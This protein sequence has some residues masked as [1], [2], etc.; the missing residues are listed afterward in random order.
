MQRPVKKSQGLLRSLPKL[1]FVC[2]RF[3]AV[4]WLSIATVACNNTNLVNPGARVSQCSTGSEIWKIVG[5]HVVEREV[6]HCCVRLAGVSW[7][8]R[9]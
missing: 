1:Y 5:V 9:Y 3:L 4:E 2:A 8:M 6:L 7:Q